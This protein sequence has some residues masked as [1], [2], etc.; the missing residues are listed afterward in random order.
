MQQ[1]FVCGSKPQNQ[2]ENKIIKIQDLTHNKVTRI[3]D[4]NNEA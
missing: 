4:Q 2:N 3:R 1:T